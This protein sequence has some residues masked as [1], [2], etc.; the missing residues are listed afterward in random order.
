LTST[1]RFLS[2]LCLDHYRAEDDFVI[3]LLTKTTDDQLLLARLP[4]NPDT[5]RNV[6]RNLI[7]KLQVKAPNALTSDQ[8]AVPNILIEQTTRFSQI[9]GRMIAG[10]EL[11]VTLAM[12][13]IDFRMDETGAKMRSDA[14]IELGWGVDDKPPPR[15]MTIEPPFAL[16]MKRKNAPHPYFVAWFANAD[17]LGAP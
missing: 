2:R 16:I 5:L 13:S 7:G 15:L 10:K 17:L 4:D 6:Y 11:L 1:I 9:E 14:V 8:L 12:Q 3:E